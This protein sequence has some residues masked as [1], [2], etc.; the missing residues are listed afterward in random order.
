MNETLDNVV[1]KLKDSKIFRDQFIRA[2]GDDA[3]TS[4]RVGLA[5][6]QFMFTMVSNNSKFDQF[7]RGQATLTPEEEHGR[8][9]FFTEFDPF[10]S[11]KGAEC[12]HCHGGFN[13]TNDQFMNNGL[14]DDAG[15]A[16]EGRSKVTQDPADHGRFKVPSLRNVALT[17][18]YMHDGRFATLEAV[19][20]HY[21]TGVKPSTTLDELMQFNIQPGGLQ[22]TAQDKADL[23][24]FLRTLT[25]TQ[26]TVNPIF[27]SP[28]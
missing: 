1:A 20:D 22:M 28:F 3:I 6:E 19:I 25:D 8:Q 7:Q 26:F 2:F 15:Q 27:S 12:F 4:D 14:D 5:L 11:E 10:G 18:P 16:D 23:V 17:G 9:L 13:F 24:A 21:N